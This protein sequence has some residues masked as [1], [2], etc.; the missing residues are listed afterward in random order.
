EARAVEGRGAAG[1]GGDRLEDVAAQ[2]EARPGPAPA[3]VGAAEEAAQLGR[4]EEAPGAVGEARRGGGLAVRPGR[5]GR[6]GGARPRRGGEGGEERSEGDGAEGASGIAH[7]G[8]DLNLIYEAAA[9][10]SRGPM[11]TCRNPD[12]VDTRKPRPYRGPHIPGTRPCWRRPTW[13]S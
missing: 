3:A 11:Q 1:V 7:G 4:Q 12:F 2:T 6:G 10:L 8:L 9:I 5:G 13:S